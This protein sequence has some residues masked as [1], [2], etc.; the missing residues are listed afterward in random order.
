[1]ERTFDTVIDLGD[2]AQRLCHVTYKKATHGC[3]LIQ[4]VFVEGVEI[5][6]FMTDEAIDSLVDQARA[7]E[8]EIS[9][10]AEEAKWEELRERR[11]AA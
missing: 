9:N 1:M 3:L 2:M 10:C 4:T 11:M 6:Q 7:N 8:I 5:T